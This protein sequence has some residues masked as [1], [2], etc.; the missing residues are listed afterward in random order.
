MK[1]T[2]ILTLDAPGASEAL[3]RCYALL[4]RWARA[5]TETTADSGAGGNQ[6]PES[7]ASDAPTE[8][9]EHRG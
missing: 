2:T 5:A 3:V 9:Q 7:A 8:E 1:T 6:Q 4:R